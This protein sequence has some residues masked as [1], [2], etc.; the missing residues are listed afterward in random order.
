MAEIMTDGIVAD[1]ALRNVTA[2]DIRREMVD[3]AKRIA[4]SSKRVID[5]ITGGSRIHPFNPQQ[6][7]AKNVGTIPTSEVKVQTLSGRVL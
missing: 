3:R 7:N 4:A 5:H 6:N 1:M 2:V